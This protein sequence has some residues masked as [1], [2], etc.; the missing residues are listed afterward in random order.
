LGTR[1]PISAVNPKKFNKLR[2]KI[3]CRFQGNYIRKH[4]RQRKEG[5]ATS[6]SRVKRTSF[7]NLKDIRYMTATEEE[8]R[9]SNAWVF[10]L[11]KGKKVK[12]SLRLTN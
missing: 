4:T 5:L 10:F 9:A 7:Y 8:I 12:L 1:L 3:Y 11:V 2:N 6:H